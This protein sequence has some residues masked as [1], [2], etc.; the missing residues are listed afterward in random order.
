MTAP[1]QIQVGPN[2]TD[3]FTIEVTPGATLSTMLPT[4]VDLTTQAN[5]S[6]TFDTMISVLQ[7]MNEQ[8]AIIGASI[9]RM[10][11]SISNMSAA[12]VKTE[13]AIGRITD[14]DFARESSNLAKQQILSNSA[15][16][17]LSTANVSKE[18]L[19]QLLQ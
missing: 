3:N 17:M 6:S 2:S 9:N 16:Q 13:I 11:A 5:A 12:A 19:L 15:N 1:Y 8:R 14:T 10:R 7:T 18:D 4:V